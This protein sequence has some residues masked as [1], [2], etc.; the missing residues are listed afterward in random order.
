MHSVRTLGNESLILMR[1][2]VLGSSLQLTVADE[3]LVQSAL[4]FAKKRERGL[5]DNI[6]IINSCILG[7]KRRIISPS[8]G[9]PLANGLARSDYTVLR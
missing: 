8:Q 5:E 1:G 2:S 7:F 9:Y 6:G 3:D 4:H